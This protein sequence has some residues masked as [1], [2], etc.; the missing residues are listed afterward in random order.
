MTL[1]LLYAQEGV[2]EDL[3][4]VTT[5]VLV[6][7]KGRFALLS[8]LPV[9]VLSVIR[10]PVAVCIAPLCILCGL[11]YKENSTKSIPG[12]VLLAAAFLGLREVCVNYGAATESLQH[13]TTEQDFTTAWS[14]AVWASNTWFQLVDYTIERMVAAPAVGLISY[15]PSLGMRWYLDAQM[16]PEHR[17]YFELLFVAQPVVCAWL[18]YTFISPKE[19]RISVSY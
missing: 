6:L 11:E 17:T 19:P 3:L 7:L 4:I 12:F 5:C 1:S 10:N 16:L 2:A 14:F 18:I 8:I 9:M 15:T 13:W